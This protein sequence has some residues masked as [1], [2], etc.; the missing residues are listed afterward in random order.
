MEALS[1]FILSIYHSLCVVK[2]YFHGMNTLPRVTKGHHWRPL[3]AL[4]F[5]STRLLT[6]SST[7]FQ[8][9]FPLSRTQIRVNG[10]NYPYPTA[11]CFLLFSSPDER[12]WRKERKNILAPSIYS[13]NKRTVKISNPRLL[14]LSAQP[15][16]ICLSVGGKLVERRR[17][18]GR[19]RDGFHRKID[20][21][22]LWGRI[23]P[24]TP[25]SSVSS[26]R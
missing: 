14:F 12:S 18:E 8:P 20:L 5:P 1:R 3:N 7:V 19:R 6:P 24:G 2:R 22:R 25:P 16:F 21:G 9:I 4:R 10:C 17:R 15:T 23:H 11:Y 26:P 13:N